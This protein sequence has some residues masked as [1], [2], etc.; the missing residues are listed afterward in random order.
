[1]KCQDASRERLPK[2]L[3]NSLGNG[4]V[5][6]KL[7]NLA[8]VIEVSR[9]YSALARGNRRVDDG[10]EGWGEIGVGKRNNC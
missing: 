4:E 7:A 8:S 10:L 5:V 6:A 2:D 3:Q 9:V 1:M